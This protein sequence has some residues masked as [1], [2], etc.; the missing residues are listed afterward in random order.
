MTVRSAEEAREAIRRIRPSQAPLV[1]DVR[2][3]QRVKHRL[4]N[5]AKRISG[6]K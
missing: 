3:D 2:I 5:S 6:G 4:W 1:M